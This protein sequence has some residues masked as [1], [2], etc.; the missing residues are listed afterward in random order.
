M[1]KEERKEV[2]LSGEEE[3]AGGGSVFRPFRDCGRGKGADA[4]PRRLQNCHHPSPV[5]LTS[6]GTIVNRTK[7]RCFCPKSPTCGS[8]KGTAVFLTLFLVLGLT[9]GKTQPIFLPPSTAVQGLT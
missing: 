5:S 4:V 2:V 3:M 6:T 1:A 9:E 8:H 7:P